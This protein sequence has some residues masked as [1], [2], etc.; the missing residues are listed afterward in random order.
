MPTE[1]PSVARYHRVS[2][3]YFRTMEVRL[4]SGS[5]FSAND[6]STEGQITRKAPRTPGVAVVNETLAK[7]LAANGSVLGRRLS[8][9]PQRRHRIDVTCDVLRR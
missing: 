7:R 5:L 4:I 9:D 2:P 1:E 3:D 8:L 6:A